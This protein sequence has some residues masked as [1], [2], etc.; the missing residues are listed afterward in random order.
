MQT[1]AG[2]GEKIDIE[3]VLTLNE[4]ENEKAEQLDYV[5]VCDGEGDY[6]TIKETE[7][8]HWY[9]TNYMYLDDDPLM[10]VNQHNNK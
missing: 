2:T 5:E 7:P 9:N 10:E 6:L 4:Q 1:M 8:V 3:I